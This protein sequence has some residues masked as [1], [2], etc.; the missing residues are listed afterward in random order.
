MRPEAK[1][2][3]LRWKET[4]LN[5]S[6]KR[7][8]QG[9]IQSPEYGYEERIVFRLKLQAQNVKVPPHRW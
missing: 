4:S 9:L 7:A 8:T 6:E 3:I 5:R 2:F 1:R